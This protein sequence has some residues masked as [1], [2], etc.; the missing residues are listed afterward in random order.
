MQQG[1]QAL[2]GL[3]REG[4]IR[5]VGHGRAVLQG[6]QA[7]LVEGMQGIEDGLVVATK[8]P[9]NV[10][11]AFATRTGKQHLAAAQHKGVLG[12]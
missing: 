6:L 2:G 5:R 10:G 3:G 11:R 4:R 1:A 7:A 12:A 9:G 8:F